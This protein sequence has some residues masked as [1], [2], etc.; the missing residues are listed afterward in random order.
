MEN[1]IIDTNKFGTD[2]KEHYEPYELVSETNPILYKVMPMFNFNSDIDI[3][4]V[5]NRMKETAILHRALGLAAPQVGLEY[6]LFIM[7]AE[8]EFFPCINPTYEL[9]NSDIVHMTEFCL[10]FPFLELNISRP[11][12]IKATYQDETGKKITRIFFWYLCKN[13]ST[14]K[15]TFTWNNISKNDKTNCIKKWIKKTR[16]TYETTCKTISR[17]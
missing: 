1:L 9:I 12:S 3:V 5:I 4:P 16:K 13:F 14:R 15:S 8:K 11:E 7:G 10:S 6:N 2:I 17:K